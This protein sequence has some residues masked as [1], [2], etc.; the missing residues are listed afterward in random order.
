[1]FLYAFVI[2]FNWNGKVPRSLGPQER[3]VERGVMSQSSIKES[4]HFPRLTSETLSLSCLSIHRAWPDYGTPSPAVSG[5][6]SGL[7]GQNHLGF[8]TPWW[9]AGIPRRL[10]GVWTGGEV[11]DS[12]RR[13]PGSSSNG[14]IPVK[15]PQSPS[16]QDQR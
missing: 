15:L 2:L 7:R 9:S 14:G 4:S 12:Q 8:P 5:G 16:A 13:H 10:G 11:M 6:W 3:A 1:M